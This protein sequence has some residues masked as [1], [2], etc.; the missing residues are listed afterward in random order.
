[1]YH[2]AAERL[3]LPLGQILHVGDDLTTD[4]AA[5]F[6]AGCRPAGSNRKART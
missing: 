3:N 1:M 6:A 4:V 2:L 5:L